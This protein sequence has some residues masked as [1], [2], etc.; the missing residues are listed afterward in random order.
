MQQ[1]PERATHL[2]DHRFDNRVD[3]MSA[4]G[5][6]AE[7]RHAKKWIALFGADNARSLSPANEADREWLTSHADSE[8]LWTEQIRSYQRDPETYLP[9]SAVNALIKREFAPAE[10]R[11]RSVTAREVAALKNLEA[12]QKNLQPSLTPKVFVDIAL[13]QMPATI[14]FFNNDV[15]LAFAKVADG[16]DKQA[17]AKANANLVLAIQDYAQWLK[18]ELMPKASGDYAIGAGAYR[19]ML[20][21]A[22]MVDI[23]LDQLEQVGIKELARLRDEF[24]KMAAQ[25]DP[26]LSPAVVMD[27]LSRE[28]P[29]A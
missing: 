23:P 28:H 17:F 21:D 29:D 27:S 24:Q 22:D 1:Y 2:G 8:L 25:I 5:I 7:I 20:N 11:M 15:P 18:N 13:Q 16:P 6:D 3:D 4:Q 12:A 10:I 19:R 14:E 26:N 9:T